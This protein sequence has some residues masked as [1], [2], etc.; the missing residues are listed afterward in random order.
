VGGT[1]HE[2]VMNA[3]YD[4]SPEDRPFCDATGTTDSGNDYK[5]WVRE[6]LEASDPDNATIDGADAGTDDSVT[7]ERLGNYHQM[8]DKVVRV[9]DRARNSNTIG[10]SDELIRQ[11]MKRQRALRRDEEAAMVSRNIAVPGTDV[12][13][14][15]LA[16]V[17]GWIGVAVLDVASTTSDR[18]AATGADPVL[19]GDSSG[20]GGFPTTAAVAGT[21]RA[22][23]ETSVKNMMR[24]AYENGGSPTMAMSTPACIEI[25]SD[26]LFTSS[27]RV[28]ALQTETGQ[29]NRTDNGTGGGR[30]GGGITAQGAVNIFV[31]NFGT[32]ELVPNRFQPEVDTDVSDLYLIDPE[33]WERT[34]LQ[35]YETKDLARTGT[36]ANRQI[37]VDA[38]LCALNPEGNAVV[39]DIDTTPAAVA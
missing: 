21:A 12:A 4:I 25:F 3:I 20:G 10:A 6:S 15:K 13:A 11:L 26:Y 36:A 9:S 23:S 14:G 35:G 19:T 8:M 2:D 1:I 33:L 28:A 31:T 30:S 5:E 34:Y 27:A 22:L 38:S 37:T 7:G 32:L 24:A 17:G 29:S 39:A 18:G 16:G